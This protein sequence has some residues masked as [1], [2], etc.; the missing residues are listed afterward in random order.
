[1]KTLFAL[2][3]G[4][5]SLSLAIPGESFSQETTL[6]DPARQ[7]AKVLFEEAQSLYMREQFKDAADRFLAA[8]DKKPFSSFLFNAAVA[9]EKSKELDKA[10]EQFQRYLAFDPQAT[11][12]AEVKVRIDTLHA[13]LSPPPPQAVEGHTTPEK[14]VVAAPVL[15][16]I[17]TKG[18]ITIDTKP[19]GATIYL[20]DKTKGVFAT[21]PW[22][23][24]LPPK[25]VK[26]LVEA[27]GFKPE[28]RQIFPRVDKVL[29]LYIALSEQHFLGW[30]EVISNVPGADVYIDQKEIGAIGKTPYTGHLKPG[31]HKLWV[32]K[33]GY[34]SSER[35]IV[36]EPG[37]ANLHKVDLEVVSFGFLH[38][39]TKTSQGAKLFV[40]GA[41]ACTMPCEQ[42]LTAGDHTIRVQ[43]EA[44]EKFEG[45]LKVERADD[46]FM[47]LNYS[48][49]PSRIPAW[50]YGVLSAGFLAG[51]IYLGIGGNKIKDQINKDAVDPIKLMRS[52]DSR[53]TKGKIYYVAADVCFG[54]SLVTGLLSLWNFLESGP[55][56]VATFKT[57]NG[58]KAPT[59]RLGLLPMDV[60]SGA[61]LT[62]TGRF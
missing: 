8:F 52:D 17:E 41:E 22:Q 54:A 58:T 47:D 2:C 35:E 24:S 27:R 49:K 12:G 46:T 10:I 61:G 42:K 34:E 29:E 56:S 32:Q 20:D 16:M 43:K 45:L 44:M 15:P 25:P 5:F 48:P 9:F 60:P 4:A 23:G 21:T 30:V 33:A 28:E 62:A 53:K 57:Q 7:E 19:T 11:D 18:F 50:T 26:V 40:D 36:V 3:F 38:A 6:T 37:T 1:M 13:I 59:N 39:G 31:K 55:P 14:P 51:G